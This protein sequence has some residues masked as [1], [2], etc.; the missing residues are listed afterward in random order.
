MPNHAHKF[1]LGLIH[2]VSK[3]RDFFLHSILHRLFVMAR[4]ILECEE[5]PI[6]KLIWDFDLNDKRIPEWFEM[7]SRFCVT[8]ITTM[9]RM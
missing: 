8:I 4:S 1:T 2:P 5:I 6:V 7:F 3:N 9:T